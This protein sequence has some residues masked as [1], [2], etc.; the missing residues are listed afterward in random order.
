[1]SGSITLHPEKGVNPRLAVCPMCGNDNGEIV[2]LGSN[3][4]LYKCGDCDVN[5]VGRPTG[6]RCPECKS[7]D[8]K[9][10][11]K[12]KDD[13]GIPTSLCSDCDNLCEE[14]KKGGV[15]WRC[16]KCHRSGALSHESPLAKE[17]REKMNI[18]PP[19][20]AGVEFNEN[21]CPCCAGGF[22]PNGKAGDAVSERE[23]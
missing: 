8:I 1:M 2:L 12:L 18:S 21:N 23:N 11:R 20:A 5:I 14:V 13:E 9:K 17:A 10:E 19:Q 15:F 22:D 3:D 6:N 4:T 16:T 7:R